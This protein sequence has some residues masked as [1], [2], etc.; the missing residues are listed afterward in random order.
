[1][2]GI[3]MPSAIRTMGNACGACLTR[4]VPAKQVPTWQSCGG[5][6][7]AWPTHCPNNVPT[8][9]VQ[10]TTD[11]TMHMYLKTTRGSSGRAARHCC[12]TSHS[13]DT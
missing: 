12:T 9:T 7:H 1:M 4:C 10:L 8:T 11:L 5:T 2:H 13:Y 3:A 6:S